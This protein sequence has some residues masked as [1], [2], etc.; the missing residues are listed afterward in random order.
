M[1]GTEIA[2]PLKEIQNRIAKNAKNINVFVIT[3][4]QVSNTE[5]IIKI[6]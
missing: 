4:G 2:K 5:E 6:N 1:G 3:D